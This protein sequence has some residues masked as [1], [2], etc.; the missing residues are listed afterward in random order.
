[1]M[2]YYGGMWG[3][4]FFGFIFG[5]VVLIDLILLGIYLWK[6]INK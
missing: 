4:N 6:K 2:N 5:L 1:M 3:G